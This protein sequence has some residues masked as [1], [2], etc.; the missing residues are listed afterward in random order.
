MQRTHRHRPKEK[1]SNA[2]VQ[3][4]KN[5]LALAH[6][7]PTIIYQRQIR[8]DC[9]AGVRIE[10]P[11][12]QIPEPPP[13]TPSAGKTYPATPATIADSL[14]PATNASH[15][16]NYDLCQ[17]CHNLPRS[18]I[19]HEE[20][21]TFRQLNN[22]DDLWEDLKI[23]EEDVWPDG[24]TCDGCREHG[25]GGARYRC[26]VCSDFDLCERC[27]ARKERHCTGGHEAGHVFRKFSA[28]EE[29]EGDSF[30]PPRPAYA[31]VPPQP[32]TYKPSRGTPQTFFDDRLEPTSL[33][34]AFFDAFFDGIDSSIFPKSTNHW[35]LVKMLAI[36]P[37][38]DGDDVDV[39]EML[40]DKMPVEYIRE[41]VP[42]TKRNHPFLPPSILTQL[43][44]KPSQPILTRTGARNY[45]IANF[46]WDPAGT[47][48]DVLKMASAYDITFPFTMDRSMA[49]V[50][51]VPEWKAKLKRIQD[52]INRELLQA[53]AVRLALMARG[54]ENSRRLL[55]PAGT[56]YV[57]EHR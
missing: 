33:F 45:M 34:E 54:Q 20:D 6:L 55:D 15:C 14:V 22:P 17:K 41:K 12:S 10:T 50:A 36:E 52:E 53:N 8:R 49:P 25:N 35:E 39:M 2:G 43:K 16:D 19:Y 47:W 1:T 23:D 18:E 4:V 48:S 7:G 51:A 26:I 44:Q 9:H 11:T 28:L 30:P 31:S 29:G 3:T 40:Y 24:Q 46:L 5:F 42:T 27:H 37:L 21:H 57:Y 38:G 32:T 56:R 13:T